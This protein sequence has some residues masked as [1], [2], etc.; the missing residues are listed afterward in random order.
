MQAPEKLTSYSFP[1]NLL[2]ILHILETSSRFSSYIVGG[3][4]RD[5]LLD[6]A[7]KEFDL[8]SSATPNEIAELFPQHSNYGKQFGSIVISTNGF[9][10]EIT[11]FRLEDNYSDH[12]HPKQIK[13]VNDIE[14]DLPRRDFTIN[15]MAYNPAT[16]VFIDCFNG[17][18]DLA[19]M[20]V[21]CIGE[22]DRRFEEDGL[23]ILRAA[24]IA[25]ELK[26]EIAPATFKAMTPS[27]L[28]QAKLSMER[29]KQE[30]C[31]I[32]YSA[33]PTFGL[34]PLY[35]SEVLGVFLPE[36]QLHA[37]IPTLSDSRY[38]S[39]R[40]KSLLVRCS[41]NEKKIITQRFML[42]KSISKHFLT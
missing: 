11:T 4:I 42:S 3:A 8:A 6:K 24:R 16:H 19:S 13:F 27:R 34:D 12:R 37:H 28:K 36:L 20:T 38:P 31:K 9:H 15:A 25:A 17:I 30:F 22:S 5:I 7:P 10:Y 35:K 29:L 21:S 32:L 23:R 40:W 39:E 33:H 1:E 26:F 2:S 41:P 14:A 18:S